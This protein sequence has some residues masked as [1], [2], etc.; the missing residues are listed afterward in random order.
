MKPLLSVIIFLLVFTL[1]SPLSYS[2][3]SESTNSPQL[4]PLIPFTSKTDMVMCTDVM[5]MEEIFNNSLECTLN[6]LYPDTTPL[7]TVE[8]YTLL[9][10]II[11]H[12]YVIT[13]ASPDIYSTDS[14]NYIKEFHFFGGSI[15]GFYD[16][17]LLTTY[18]TQNVDMVAITEHELQHHILNVLGVEDGDHTN[19]VWFQCRPPRYTPSK[20]AERGNPYKKSG[21]FVADVESFPKL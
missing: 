13:P 2:E 7:I 16:P 11:S 8:Q 1:G 17:R 9:R 3:D 10:S 18:I 21:K 6:S 12:C 14:Y 19:G 15:L 4:H 20:E 5:D